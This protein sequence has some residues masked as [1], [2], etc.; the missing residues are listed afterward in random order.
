MTVT[1]V[2]P[3]KSSLKNRAADEALEES[4]AS[5]TDYALPLYASRVSAGFPSPAD[6]YIEERIDLN[7]HLVSRP[8]ATFF[9]R[10]RGDSMIDKGIF[11]SDLLIVDRS[12][13][14]VTGAVVIAVVNGEMV[15]KLLDPE[16]QQLLAANAN[17]PPIP[18][19]EGVDCVIEGVVTHAVRYLS[20]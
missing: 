7:S 4:R 15:C 2:N 13:T 19:H 18:I 10:V 3:V 1:L 8:A 20:V 17:Y 5:L 11:D 16:R 6:D 14:P 9:A 12:K